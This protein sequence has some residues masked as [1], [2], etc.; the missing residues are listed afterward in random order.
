[1]EKHGGPKEN[2][3]GKCR[4]GRAKYRI[5]YSPAQS[6]RNWEQRREMGLVNNEWK[7]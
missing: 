3:C 6:A 1:M 7:G 4:C 5:F 2:M